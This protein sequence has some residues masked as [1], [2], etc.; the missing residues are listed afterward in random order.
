MRET[1]SEIFMKKFNKLLDEHPDVKQVDVA[2]AIGVSSATISE[3]RKGRKS[4]R[5]EKV[6]MVAAYFGVDVDYFFTNARIP[7]Y[8]PDMLNLIEMYS[9]LTEQKKEM[10]MNY[11]KFLRNEQ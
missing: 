6:K 5:I 1:L 8:T 11:V 4:P 7:D 2:K 10:L 3:W 9:D